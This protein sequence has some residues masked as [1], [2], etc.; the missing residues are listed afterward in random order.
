MKKQV[1]RKDVKSNVLPPQVQLE[2]KKVLDSRVKKTTKHKVYMEHQI[3][4][5]HRLDLEA[6]WTEIEDFNKLGITKEILSI[7]VT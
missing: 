1:I 7:G 4:W 3:K 5:K 2:A 6:T